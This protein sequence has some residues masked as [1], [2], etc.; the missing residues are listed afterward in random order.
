MQIKRILQHIC[1]WLLFYLIGIYTELFLS[2]SF[3]NEPSIELAI[4]C[5]TAQFCILFVKIVGVYYTLLLFIP[6]WIKR[7]NRTKLYLES[8]VVLI[9]LL[10]LY[11]LVIHLIIW[12]FIYHNTPREMPMVTYIARLFYSLVDISQIVGIAAAIKLFK[13]RMAALK[14]EKE[15]IKQK[16][17]S[18]L[19]HLKAQINPHFLFN[20]LNSVYSLSRTDSALASETIVRLSKILRYM[21]YESEKQLTSVEDELKILKE[22]IDLQQLRFGKG[23][24]IDYKEN[25]DNKAEL[26]PPLILLPLIEN[27]YKHGSGSVTM[28]STIDVNIELKK[29]TIVVMVKNTITTESIVNKETKGIGLAN[30]KR[31]LELLFR[32]FKFDYHSEGEYFFVNLRIELS[33]YAGFELFNS[34]R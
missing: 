5:F 30:I 16:L 2:P 9:L 34:R 29:S 33:T 23:V 32:D 20:A 11:R 14:S 21:L 12:P 25:I 6:R 18:E 24:N 31:Q 17:E 19:L 3:F 8:V 13:L 22:Y 10:I 26:I 7:T 15:L 28:P 27:A 1:F 4:E